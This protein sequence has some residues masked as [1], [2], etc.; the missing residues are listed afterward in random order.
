MPEA[1]L[2]VDERDSPWPLRPWIMAAICAMAGV[3]FQALLPEAYSARGNITSTVGATFVA[4]AALAFVL[5]VEPRRWW[6]A[7]IFALGWGLIIGVIAMTT[8]GQGSRRC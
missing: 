8:T 4:V 6:W 7:L 1:S 3:I 2:R 5:T